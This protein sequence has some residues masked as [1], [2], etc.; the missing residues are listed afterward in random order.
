[1]DMT[2]VTPSVYTCRATRVYTHTDACTHTHMYTHTC[3]HTHLEI[4]ISD[5]DI[6]MPGVIKVGILKNEFQHSN[7]ISCHRWLHCVFV[8]LCTINLL[9]VIDSAL[10]RSRTNHARSNLADKDTTAPFANQTHNQ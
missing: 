1:M 8:S 3:M 7:N 2:Y 10:T 6:K 5:R 9:I 4:V